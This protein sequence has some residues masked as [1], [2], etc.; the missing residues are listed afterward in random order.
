M[1][2]RFKRQALHARKLGLQHP[3]SGEWMEWSVEPPQDMREL[4]TVLEQDTAYG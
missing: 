1:L 3:A 2:R 4:L